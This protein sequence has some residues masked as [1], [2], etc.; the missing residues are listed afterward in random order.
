MDEFFPPEIEDL[1]AV[2]SPPDRGEKT[3]GAEVAELKRRLAQDKF[4]EFEAAFERPDW[5]RR[6]GSPGA[7]GR[8]RANRA[9]GK[10]GPQGRHAAADERTRPGSFGTRRLH[11]QHCL[12][13]ARTG[14]G[15]RFRSPTSVR[16]RRAPAGRSPNTPRLAPTLRALP[17]GWTKAPFPR[18]RR[19]AGAIWRAD[20][21]GGDLVT[22]KPC[23]FVSRICHIVRG[24]R[25]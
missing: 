2:A 24:K 8:R 21:G 20:Q 22:P 17:R 14:E 25:V 1:I 9:A 7:C 4:D 18:R 5:R 3:G 16:S 11:C 10:K 19:L 6:L 13:A 12:Q 23:R 15:A